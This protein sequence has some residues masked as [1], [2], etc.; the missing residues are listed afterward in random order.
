MTE[1]STPELEKRPQ[2]TRL[3]VV[4]FLLTFQCSLYKKTAYYIHSHNTVRFVSSYI[5]EVFYIYE[6]EKSRERCETRQNGMGYVK[7]DLGFGDG[8]KRIS[9]SL[10][11]LVR[12]FPAE[13]RHRVKI[14]SSLSRVG[15][16]IRL[17]MRWMESQLIPSQ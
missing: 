15:G 6:A 3:F 16:V 13:G 5:S 7:R 4:R 10:P 12:E 1:D 17:L 11:G 9:A 8:T 2:S 14:E